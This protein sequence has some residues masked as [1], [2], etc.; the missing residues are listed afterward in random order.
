[1]VSEDGTENADSQSGCARRRLPLTPGRAGRPAHPLYLYESAGG[2]G[3]SPMCGV[4]AALIGMGRRAVACRPTCLR[5][6][7][8]GLRRSSSIFR[9]GPMP[10]QP[11]RSS[12]SWKATSVACSGSWSMKAWFRAK[13][14][15]IPG[16]P[17]E[18]REFLALGPVVRELRRSRS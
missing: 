14:R 18:A 1:M 16:A 12:R 10:W 7:H 9:A 2:I 6:H 13:R 15:T 17:L 3:Y 5:V 4:D 8:E 11:T